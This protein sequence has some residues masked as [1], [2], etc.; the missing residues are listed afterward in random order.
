MVCLVFLLKSG[1]KL[2]C[3]YRVDLKYLLLVPHALSRIASQQLI[4]REIGLHF[5]ALAEPSR[6]DSRY[7]GIHSGYN[8]QEL[9]AWHNQRSA[10]ILTPILIDSVFAL[11]VRSLSVY[12]VVSDASHIGISDW[13]VLILRR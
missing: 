5:M 7:K 11:Q 4:F 2:L 6:A 1:E 8:E 10:D 9:D 12:A 3:L 13:F